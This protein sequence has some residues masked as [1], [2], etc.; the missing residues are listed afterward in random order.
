L[1]TYPLE[2]IIVQTYIHVDTLRLISLDFSVLS[3][4]NNVK[5]RA[6]IIGSIL[7]CHLAN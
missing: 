4:H 6:E 1:F 3:V 5:R 2:T 7:V